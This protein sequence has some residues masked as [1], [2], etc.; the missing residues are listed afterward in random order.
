VREAAIVP[1]KT[2]KQTEREDEMNDL[3]N[4]SFD[5]MPEDAAANMTRGPVI[6]FADNLY[7]MNG[8]PLKGKDGV[9]SY[10]AVGIHMAWVK[11]V[12]DKP[13]HVLP[14]PNGY[15][16]D[17]NTLGDLDETQW[18][19]PFKEPADPWQNTR[20]LHLF[21]SDTAEVFTFVTSSGGGRYAIDQLVGQIKLKRRFA[22]GVFPII[23]L[24]SAKWGKKFPKSRPDFKVVGWTAPPTQ[25]SQLPP[26]SGSKTQPRLISNPLGG[27]EPP[28]DFNDKIPF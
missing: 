7:R 27:D 4:D 2:S 19:C 8:E 17:R 23:E 11:F 14:G 18:E 22:P 26:P 25:P 16:P 10:T 28:P 24:S 9:L 1:G 6:K 12:E 3:T 20:Y 5:R 13:I 21:D 15:L